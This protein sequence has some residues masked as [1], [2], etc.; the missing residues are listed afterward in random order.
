MKQL[1]RLAVAIAATAI[2]VLAGVSSATAATSLEVGGAPKNEAVAIKASAGGSLLL[3]ATA[4]GFANT[5][6][7][8]TVEGSTEAP[9]SGAT[10]GGKVSS[11]TFA[12]CT[13]EPVTV[14][15]AGTLTV[16]NISG[17]TNGT[18]RSNGAKVT[19]GS[20]FGS[21]TCT[22][23]GTDLGTL[24]GV[25]SGKATID[26]NAVLNCG[27][28]LPSAKWEGSYTVTSPEGLGVTSVPVATSLEV[29]GAP[30]NE[31]VAI[32]A[33]AGGSLLLSAT[34]GGFANTCT[35]STVEGSTEAPFSGATV[36][37]KV[38]SLTFAKCTNEP[39]TVDSAG[40]LTVE[41]ISGTTNGTIRSN[42]AKVTTGSPFG[43]LTCTTSGTDLGT[44]T[45]VASGK[46]TIDVNAVLNCGFFL[47]SAKWEGSYTVTSPEG[48]GVTS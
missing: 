48:L 40:T 15:S 17:T 19:T 41:N 6:T 30:K 37:G 45:G 44:L 16:E 1:Q 29:G 38:S 31:A 9:F 34:A 33:S 25:A 28:F 24:T 43:S 27:F 20:P 2:F 12:K 18:I 10:V 8:S 11:L 46:A 22:T 35:E 47:P 23:S 36:G 42:G 5:C 32:K 3:S 39:V 26:V 7:E 4:G 14:D 21:L 13:N